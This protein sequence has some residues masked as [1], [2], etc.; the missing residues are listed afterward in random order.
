MSAPKA[1]AVARYINTYLG[2]KAVA[3][4]EADVRVK[5]TWVPDAFAVSEDEAITFI[6]KIADDLGFRPT[7]VKVFSGAAGTSGRLKFVSVHFYILPR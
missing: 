2:P 4:T 7:F 5:W 6:E 3:G 1:K